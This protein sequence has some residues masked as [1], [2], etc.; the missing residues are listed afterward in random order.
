MNVMNVVNVCPFKHVYGHEQCS[1]KLQGTITDG[2]QL[3]GLIISAACTM[4]SCQLFQGIE[5]VAQ[6]IGIT[7]V[8]TLVAHKCAKTSLYLTGLDLSQTL[9][10]MYVCF[11]IQ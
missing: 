10:N 11:V 3:L 2:I 5:I 8:E 7:P 9:M 4:K 6:D 1:N